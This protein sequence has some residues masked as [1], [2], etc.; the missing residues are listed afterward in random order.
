MNKIRQEVFL[1]KKEDYNRKLEY[2]ASI[3]QPELW[4]FQSVK[5]TDPYRIL[6]N[7]F[8]FTYDRLSEEEKFEESKDGEYR[9]MNT[10]LLT[11]YDQEIVA[12]FLRSH[13]EGYLPWFLVGFFRDSDRKF[14]SLF[15]KVPPLADYGGNAAD[16]IFDKK[17]EIS[18][19]KIHIIDDNFMRFMEAGY[20]DKG[21]IDALLESAHQKL[22]KKLSR[23]F[24]LALPFYYHNTDTDERKIQLLV[25]LYFP[26]SAVKLALVLD[27]RTVQDGGQYYEAVTVLPVEWAYMNARL[28]VRPDEEW[29]KIVDELDS[30]L[31]EDENFS[32]IA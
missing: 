3:A 9:C 12:L 13:R 30:P 6:R 16:L 8:Q 27:K 10:G 32:D 2:L 17:L 24:K 31:G 22:K 23:N 15:S 18:L 5:A 28:I 20:S 25:P 7:Y 26:N 11:G 4:T 1:G 19:N 14:Q 21:L 29:A